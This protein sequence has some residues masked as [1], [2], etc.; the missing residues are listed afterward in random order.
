MSKSVLE[1]D[2]V[3]VCV[4]TAGERRAARGSGDAAG[5]QRTAAQADPPAADGRQSP[6]AAPG[7]PAA[8]APARGGRRAAGPA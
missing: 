2:G 8:A 5:G 7:R 3:V 4:L 6:E 1:G